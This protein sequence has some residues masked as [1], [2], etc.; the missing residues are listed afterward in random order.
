M[1]IG[2]CGKAGAG[3]TTVCGILL[4]FLLDGGIY[5]L[6]DDLKRIARDEFGWTGEKDE[7]G[8]RLLQT[9]GTDCGR[10]YGGENF[11]VDKWYRNIMNHIAKP[12]FNVLVDDVRFENE[13]EFIKSHGGIIVK[14]IGRSFDLG[15]NAS[16]ASEK[17]LPD[18]LVDFTIDNSGDFQQ[19]C[20]NVIQF[21]QEIEIRYFHNRS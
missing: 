13:A 6:A 5:P 3:K 9:L 1:I 17:G 18:N 15:P 20:A 19:L 16:H 11:W 4:Q 8:R 21:N 12:N 10:M 2:F 14:V 7:N